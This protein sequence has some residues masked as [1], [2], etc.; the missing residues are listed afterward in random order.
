MIVEI[1]ISAGALAGALANMRS[2]LDHNHCAPVLFRTKSGEQPDII[3]I[4]VEFEADADATAFR[5]A[6]DPRARIG[7]GDQPR[8]E[9]VE[10]DM[11]NAPVE[12]RRLTARALSS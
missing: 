12:T 7:E 11:V 5:L 6:F 10:R 2:W 1:A 4:R 9:P 8:R 3:L